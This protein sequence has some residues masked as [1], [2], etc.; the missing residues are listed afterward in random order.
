MLETRNTPVGHI[1]FV[2]SQCCQSI[3]YLISVRG[4]TIDSSPGPKGRERE[5]VGGQPAAKPTHALE[6]QT[7]FLESL[8]EIPEEGNRE[9]E[10]QRRNKVGEIFSFFLSAGR[11]VHQLQAQTW[12]D[13]LNIVITTG[14]A[15]FC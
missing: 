13:A 7:S 3:K 15:E 5:R 8:P 11:V 10:E 14:V 6:F 12:T 9:Q 4:G 2:Q 1:V